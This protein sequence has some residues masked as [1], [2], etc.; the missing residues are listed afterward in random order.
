M[1][2]K[3]FVV[4]TLNSACIQVKKVSFLSL[5]DKKLTFSSLSDKKLIFFHSMSKIFYVFSRQISPFW[6]ILG[7]IRKIRIFFSLSE[8][9]RKIRIFLIF[10]KWSDLSRFDKIGYFPRYDIWFL[11]FSR[12]RKVLKKAGV[13]CKKG[14]FYL[15]SK[16]FGGPNL[17]WSWTEFHVMELIWT[18]LVWSLNEQHLVELSD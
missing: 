2:K 17:R 15:T 9:I 11:F 10:Q 4:I 3:I 8:K 1:N 12:P 14:A 5:S 13:L 6:T 16:R 7:T 18:L